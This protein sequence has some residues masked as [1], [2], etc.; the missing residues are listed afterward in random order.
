MATQTK[1]ILSDEDM[2]SSLPV[3]DL[4]VNGH[5]VTYSIHLACRLSLADILA[6]AGKPLS[7]SEIVEKIPGEVNSNYLTR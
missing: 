7:V 5:T 1:S 4:L 6:E 3:L 2:D